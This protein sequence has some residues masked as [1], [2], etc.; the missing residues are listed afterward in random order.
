M[1]DAQKKALVAGLPFLDDLLGAV[2]T[3]W[4]NFTKSFPK[5]IPEWDD[6]TVVEKTWKKWTGYF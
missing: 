1:E 5:D 2:T 6:K 3:H 4:I